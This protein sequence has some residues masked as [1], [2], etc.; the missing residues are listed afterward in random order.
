MAHEADTYFDDD[1]DINEEELIAEI[2]REA[3]EAQDALLKANETLNA[4]AT[5]NE[6][7]NDL[8]TDTGDAIPDDFKPGAAQLT[9]FQDSVISTGSDVSLLLMVILVILFIVQMIRKTYKHS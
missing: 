3:R 1:D 7:L 4:N 2:E 8:N 9:T 6:T 5:L